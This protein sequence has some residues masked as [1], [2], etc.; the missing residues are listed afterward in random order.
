MGKIIID[1]VTRI[2][3]HLKVEVTL[4]GGKV[5]E[6]RTSGTLFRGF[7][8]IL[9]GRDP[10][11]ASQITQRVC[12]V[13]PIAHATASVFALDQAFNLEDKIPSNA[14]IIR[15]LILGSN[16]LQ[17]NILHFYHLASLDF[18][19]LTRLARYEGQDAKLKSLKQFF[20][21]GNSSPFLPRYQGDYRL[22]DKDNEELASHYLLAL[23]MR[24]KTHELLAIFGGKMPHNV[25][26]VAGGVTEKPTVDKIASF[27]WR[28]NEIREFIDNIY[29]KDVLRIAEKYG[30]YLEMGASDC[31]FLS[32]GAFN[33]DSDEISQ[34]RRSRLY[35][36][37]LADSALNC[38]ALEPARITEQVKN[39]W[40]KDEFTNR[41]PFQGETVPSENKASG[42][43]WLKAP[44]YDGEPCEVGPLA[45]LMVGYS[46]NHSLVQDLVKKVLSTMKL[47]LSALQSCLGRHLARALDAKLVADAM[48]EW[49]LELKPG[50][51][52]YVPYELPEEAEGMGLS[53][54]PRGSVGHWIRIKGGFIAN[55]QLVVPTTWNASPRDDSNQPG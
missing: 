23:E 7:E 33:L 45:R 22:D 43:S 6:A 1:P 20:A 35:K 44:R 53:E 12:G 50:E 32:Y 52:I 17:S 34:T 5:K 8:I 13:C 11:D 48:A 42:Y 54:A 40:Y 28:L 10:R 14:R 19:D 2:E 25:G 4:D 37:G 39:S 41:H 24:R 38:S 18:V 47:E 36:Q 16:F 21:G 31:R 15:N 46:W 49:V 3:G 26:M 51:P 27:L 29:L 9:K 30:D 55:Y